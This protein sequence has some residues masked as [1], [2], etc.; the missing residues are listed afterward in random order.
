MKRYFSLYFSA[1]CLCFALSLVSFK[2]ASAEESKEGGELAVKCF[3]CHESFDELST[4]EPAFEFT[5]KEGD[6]PLKI[7]PHKYVPH[8]SKTVPDCLS[9]HTP[10]K[11]DITEA[12]QA[13][14]AKI[15]YCFGCHHEKTF[16]KCADCHDF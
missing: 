9:C 4:K 2:A 3:D 14:K 7:N 1:L 6:K 8:E 13:P 16:A 11:V 12:S 10:H 5:A 15:D